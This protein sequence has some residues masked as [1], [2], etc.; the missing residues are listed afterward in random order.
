MFVAHPDDETVVW[1]IGISDHWPALHE[2]WRDKEGFLRLVF[3]REDYEA[4]IR[5]MLEAVLTVGSP[6]LPPVEE[7]EPDNQHGEAYEWLQSWAS[8]NDWS[9][10][11]LLPEGTTLEFLSDTDRLRDGKPLREYVP[12][13]LTRWTRPFWRDKPTPPRPDHRR[14]RWTGVRH[15]AAGMLCRGQDS[16]RRHR[17]LRPHRKCRR[18]GDGG[19]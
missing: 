19:G 16:T 13:L 4:D 17:N 5:A 18:W 7:Y 9:R 15:R 14:C 8:A 3:R 2:R 12:H 11:P 10:Q 6:D 1:K